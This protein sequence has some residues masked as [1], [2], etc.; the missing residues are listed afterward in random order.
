M[1]IGYII[2]VVFGALAPIVSSFGGKVR[3]LGSLAAALSWIATVMLLA[4]AVTSLIVSRDMVS[5]L[6]D[7]LGKLGLEASLGKL[8]YIPFGAF[9]LSFV[10]SCLFGINAIRAGS[11]AYGSRVRAVG[12]DAGISDI[13]REVKS[14]KAA[15]GIFQRATTWS[16]HRYVQ[17]ERQPEV[18]VSQTP[19]YEQAVMM[20]PSDEV[21]DS[22]TVDYKNPVA[23]RDIAMVPLSH[24]G[25]R[26]DLI[27]EPY[28]SQVA[29]SSSPGR[30]DHGLSPGLSPRYDDS[31]P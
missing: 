9:V 16:R 18:K 10:A 15:G 24:G 28:A 23:E 3:T 19:G 7:N 8:A 17:V 2:A 25:N 21:Q 14:A 5:A 30:S 20:D 22:T 1:S 27:Y 11:A 31:P 6:N 29:R 13:D 12:V 26:M 4:D